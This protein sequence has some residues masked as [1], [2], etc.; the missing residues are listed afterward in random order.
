MIFADGTVYY[1]S[2]TNNAMAS[3]RAVVQFGNGDRYKGAV[4]GNAKSGDGE[5][6]A[7]GA[8][9]ATTYEGRFQHDKRAGTGKFRA[10]DE[11]S[12]RTLLEYEGDYKEDKRCGRCEKLTVHDD[13]NGVTMLYKGTLN[14]G[15]ELNG[16]D[17]C[18]LQVKKNGGEEV[19]R[20]VGGFKSNAF[21]GK[22]RIEYADTGNVFA[23]GFY[24][25]VK[26][27]EASFELAER[28][29]LAEVRKQA[30]AGVWHGT[31]NLGG[32]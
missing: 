2:F 31:F 23:G 28:T 18:E 19:F 9:I 17:A 20:Y 13:A 24:R 4:N 14:E 27:G 10:E 11:S 30:G 3:Q 7:A 6:H 1:G 16:Y 29:K 26:H 8:T 22:G 25:G 15:E 12:R 5:Y 32:C 21:D